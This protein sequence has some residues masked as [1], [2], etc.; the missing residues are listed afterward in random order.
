MTSC[1]SAN[2]QQGTI[3]QAACDTGY[4]GDETKVC[5]VS[6]RGMAEGT[7]ALVFGPLGRRRSKH[8]LDACHQQRAPLEGMPSLGCAGGFTL[9][10]TTRNRMP[11]A[12][13]LWRR[14]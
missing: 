1:A 8:S 10:Q 11:S 4:Y 3:C 5:Q 7:G 6:G 12:A 9:T 2:F 13:G 14:L